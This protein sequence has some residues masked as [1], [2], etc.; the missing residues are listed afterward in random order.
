MDGFVIPLRD[1]RHPP[2]SVNVLPFALAL[3]GLWVLPIARRSH[4]LLAAAL[5]VAALLLV[6]RLWFGSWWAWPLGTVLLVGGSI[7][8][9]FLAVSFLVAAIMAMRGDG[10]P[11]SAWRQ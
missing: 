6:D 1:V 7:A 5:A 3:G 4:R 10:D 8:I 9:A 11:E 2:R